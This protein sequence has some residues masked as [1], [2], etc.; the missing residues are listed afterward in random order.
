MRRLNPI[1]RVFLRIEQQDYPMDTMGI[2]ILEPTADGPLPFETVQAAIAQRVAQTPLLR[3]QLAQT[4]YGWGMEQWMQV[5]DVDLDHHLTRAI[6]PPPGDLRSLLDLSV[7]LSATPLD[8]RRPLWRAWYAESA[9]QSRTV[10][11]IRA[12]QAL[13]DGLGGLSV[14][15]AFFDTRPV[16][17][18]PARQPEQLPGETPPTMSEMLAQAVPEMISAVKGMTGQTARLIRGAHPRPQVS[19]RPADSRPRTPP[20]TPFEQRAGKPAKTL[21]AIS[22]PRADVEAVRQVRPDLST[23]DVLLTLL[24][25]ALRSYLERN[26][27]LP[28]RPLRVAT[29]TLVPG[30]SEGD[31]AFS[32]MLIDLPVEVADRAER[33]EMV[34]RLNNK[35]RAAYQEAKTSTDAV[36]AFSQLVH[37]GLVAPVTIALGN[38]AMSFLPPLVNLTFASLTIPGDGPRYFAGT[39]LAHIYGRTFVLPPQQ[40]FVHAVVYDQLVEFGV[41]SLRQP[42]PNPEVLMTLV[43]AELDALVAHVG[44]G[45]G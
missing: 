13:V 36:S 7:R 19:E 38:P 2:Y 24:T 5:E 1:Q 37:P 23:G 21:A 3:R 9:A 43:R 26:H 42:L 27:A 32:V 11:L 16:A 41:T 25:G 14:Y 30:R 6:V 34:H 45:G 12:H 29:P 17:V 15:D 39:K 18:D 22:L 20:R 4:S 31:N 33:L 44:A 28:D 10:L 8:R 40:V 35:R